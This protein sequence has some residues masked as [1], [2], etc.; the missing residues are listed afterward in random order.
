MLMQAE[1]VQVGYDQPLF[2]PLSFRL[3]RGE[4]V[5]L[6]GRNG[7]GKTSL[8]HALIAH[9]SGVESPVRLLHGT[10]HTAQKLHVVE[11]KQHG[12]EEFIGNTLYGSVESLIQATGK[13][14]SDMIIRRTL[15]QYMFDPVADAEKQFTILSGG[16]KARLSLMRLLLQSPDVMIL[17]EPTNHLDLPSIE[18]LEKMLHGYDGAVLYVSHDSY[19]ANELAGEPIE[20]IAA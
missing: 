12:D 9:A 19:F 13:P 8:I 2:K 10:L 6:M 11:Y 4:R 1:N 16:E 7:V 5:R 14:V 20:L 3:A 15:S 18:E 17:D